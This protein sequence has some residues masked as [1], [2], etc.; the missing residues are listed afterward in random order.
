MIFAYANVS[1]TK[2][3]VYVA[4]GLV[5]LSLKCIN[6]YTLFIRYVYF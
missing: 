6:I 4:I 5:M 1:K 3:D 2:A